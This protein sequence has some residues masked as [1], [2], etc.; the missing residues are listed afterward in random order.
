MSDYFDYETSITVNG[1]EYTVSGSLEAE[2]EDN[3]IGD[4]EYWGA[5][6]NDTH[7]VWELQDY[8]VSICDEEGKPVNDKELTMLIL[9][10]FDEKAKDYLSE[11]ETDRD[12]PLDD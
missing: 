9:G 7:W 3:G 8:A 6:G 12:E 1:I 2:L 4:Y 11:M 10:K 5:T